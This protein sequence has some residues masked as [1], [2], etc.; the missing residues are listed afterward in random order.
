LKEKLKTIFKDEKKGIELF[1]NE[2]EEIITL[3][4]DIHTWHPAYFI[5]KKKSKAI[6][7]LDQSKKDIIERIKIFSQSSSKSLI[8]KYISNEILQNLFGSQG[9]YKP[10][11]S[12]KL[13]A[14]M[15]YLMSEKGI[16]FPSCGIHGINQMVY[17]II[18]KNKGEVKL[19]TMVTE[20]LIEN[21]EAI[22]VKTSKNEVFSAKWIISNID[23]KNTFLKLIDSQQISPD[24]LYNLKNWSLT[25]SE[26][27]IFLGIKR[28]NLDLSKIKAQHVFY[29]KEIK[30]KTKYDPED[31][32][33]EEIEICFWSENFPES[34]PSDRLIL[35]LRVNLPFDHVSKWWLVEK[36][37][38]NGYIEYKKGLADKVIKIVEDVLPG[39]SSA[40][41]IME[42]ATPLT[43]QDWGNR[44]RGTFAGWSWNEKDIEKL[45]EKLLIKTPINNLLMVGI[46]A[47]SELFLGGYPTAIF[48]ANSA[49]DLIL[50]E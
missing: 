8:E 21:N 7:K 16:W 6:N 18:L 4:K 41:E 35:V 29:R 45:N 36:K 46:Y 20:I 23:Y 49:V 37:R 31:F 32:E 39:L 1:I 26:L 30:V 11:M 14:N 40:I 28:K 15:W 42:I 33:K 44:Y 10:K 24:F 5:G 9:T 34:A 22:G 43:Y 27:C 48:T 19:S 47:T 12:I 13:L 17:E 50:E 3:I 25:E 2:L 38:K